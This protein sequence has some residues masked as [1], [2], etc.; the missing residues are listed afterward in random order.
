MAPMSVCS[1]LREMAKGRKLMEAK[2]INTGIVAAIWGGLP[3]YPGH[4]SSPGGSP[5]AGHQELPGKA[6]KSP[7]AVRA[8]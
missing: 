6:A 2:Q 1:R 8:G 7:R 3:Q 5:D 4:H